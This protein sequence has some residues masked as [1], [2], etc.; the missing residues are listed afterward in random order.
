MP[1]RFGGIGSDERTAVDV[2][3]LKLSG[4]GFDKFETKDEKPD[5]SRIRWCVGRFGGQ[6]VRIVI[7][8]EHVRRVEYDFRL[9]FSD[10][11]TP[12]TVHR[13]RANQTYRQIV[14]VLA[15]SDRE[16]VLVEQLLD[17]AMNIKNPNYETVT[18]EMR[19]KF[20]GDDMEGAFR[21]I[22]TPRNK[23]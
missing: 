21:V 19:I 9:R 6:V 2:L 4:D 3:E 22:F 13:S 16:F 8:Q 15:G 23:N 14:S 1:V 18:N 7:E 11:E 5:G 17:A 10:D 20:S 12:S